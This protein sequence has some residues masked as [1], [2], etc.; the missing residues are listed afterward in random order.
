MLMYLIYSLISS[1][2]IINKPNKLYSC[3][4]LTAVFLISPIVTIS[5]AV[6]VPA[7]RDTLVHGKATVVL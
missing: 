1:L 2:I 6:T 3:V 5:F 4:K 7:S